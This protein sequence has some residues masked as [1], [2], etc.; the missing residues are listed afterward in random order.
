MKVTRPEPTIYG[1]C[2]SWNFIVGKKGGAYSREDRPG[3]SLQVHN[4]KLINSLSTNA[5]GHGWDNLWAIC[6]APVDCHKPSRIV[7]KRLS[8]MHRKL[9]RSPRILPNRVVS[10]SLS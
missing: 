7:N 9:A 4:M 2:D 8:F 3:G 6:G 1:N 10:S 5:V